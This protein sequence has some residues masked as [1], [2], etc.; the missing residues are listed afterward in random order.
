MTPE[1]K[2]YLIQDAVIVTAAV[3]LL[4]VPYRMLPTHTKSDVV[5]PVSTAKVAGPIDTIRDVNALI[6]EVKPIVD[7]AIKDGEITIKVKLPQPPKA[8]PAEV[9]EPSVVPDGTEANQQQQSCPGGVCPSN[10]QQSYQP[11]RRLFGR[12]R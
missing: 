12:W 6:H 4:A 10:Q 8:V 11:V 7:Q 5:T 3:I 2:N 1:T 9:V